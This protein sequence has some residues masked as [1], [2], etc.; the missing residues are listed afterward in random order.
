MSSSNYVWEKMHVA[1]SC[2][3]DEG[4]FKTRLANATVSA[5]VR[6]DDDDL[7]GELKQDLKYILDW[8]KGNLMNG[9]IQREPN[10]LERKKLIEKMLH[11]LHETQGK[12]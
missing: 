4:N 8:T 2:L 12:V 10:E 1:I 11:V 3:C 9:V 7:S 6:L 5:L